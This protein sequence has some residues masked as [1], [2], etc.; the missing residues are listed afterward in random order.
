MDDARGPMDRAAR[1][2]RLLLTASAK[3][4]WASAD[5]A[6]LESI[7]VAVTDIVAKITRSGLNAFDAASSQRAGTAAGPLDIARFRAL[8][9]LFGALHRLA[10]QN[11]SDLVEYLRSQ[12]VAANS[13][14][15]ALLAHSSTER[16]PRASVPAL[17]SSDSTGHLHMGAYGEPTAAFRPPAADSAASSISEESWA[18][19]VVEYQPSQQMSACTVV[20][21]RALWRWRRCVGRGQSEAIASVM[22]VTLSF[23][24]WRSVIYRKRYCAT[25]D[26]ME[27]HMEQHRQAMVAASAELARAAQEHQEQE[28]ALRDELSQRETSSQVAMHK[29]IEMAHA[30]HLLA[31]QS[32]A[33]EHERQ[34]GV[35]KLQLDSEAANCTRAQA[36][37]EGIERREMAKREENRSLSEQ[38]QV[39]LTA[40][41]T[42][43][44]QQVAASMGASHRGELAAVQARSELEFQEL[45]RSHDFEKQELQRELVSIQ[46]AHEK[47]VDNASTSHVQALEQAHASHI[48]AQ[49]KAAEKHSAS[50]K[51]LKAAH[52]S[53]LRAAEMSATSA[54]T[55]EH[56]KALILL[57]EEVE[58][59]RSQAALLRTEL[60]EEA[61]RAAAQL[62]LATA[63]AGEK[64]RAALAQEEANRIEHAA[65]MLAATNQLQTLQ[66]QTEAATDQFQQAQAEVQCVSSTYSQLTLSHSKLVAYSQE[67]E[68]RER[69]HK[70]ELAQAQQITSDLEAKLAE[71]DKTVEQV[72]RNAEAMIQESR[73]ISLAA[74]KY[75]REKVE[76]ANSIVAEAQQQLELLKTGW[77]GAH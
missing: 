28:E 12:C 21:A 47:S 56:A 30:E 18:Q 41:M 29:E 33:N 62:A 44:Q 55:A 42:E 61:S 13:V 74:K 16:G 77:M 76:H 35:L 37:L 1:L 39:R 52:A 40:V 49:T 31:M 4:G 25:Q 59:A 45:I 75:A 68:D 72:S 53:A 8:A 50:M 60:H 23:S 5:L 27:V 51:E 20:C 64:V 14:C 46:A 63:A 54:A 17:A 2:C 38:Q 73:S 32:A 3:E 71:A 24:Q 66:S 9:T 7:A 10:C 36:A 22:R 58:S 48:A 11:S 70:R 34:L 19:S 67:Q 43:A 6:D 57:R 69:S 15:D 26:A 65:A